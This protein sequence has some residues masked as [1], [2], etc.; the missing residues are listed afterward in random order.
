M[1]HPVIAWAV[2]S[3]TGFMS[4]AKFCNGTLDKENGSLA[5]VHVLSQEGPK[6]TMYILDY[7]GAGVVHLLGM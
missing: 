7:A 4:A 6:N 2:W 3:Q 1:I 5:L